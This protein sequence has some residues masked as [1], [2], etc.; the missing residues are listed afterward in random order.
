MGKPPSEEKNQ[1][2]AACFQSVSLPMKRMRRLVT[3]ETTKVSM[4]ER[5][6]PGASTKAPVA[7][8]FSRPWTSMRRRSLAKKAIR[9]RTKR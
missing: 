8:M 7:G 1:S 2:G 6:A 3:T 5:C 4:F 9:A